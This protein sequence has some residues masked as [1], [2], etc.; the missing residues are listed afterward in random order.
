MPFKVIQGHRGG[1]KTIN[2]K[3]V[4]DF[5]LVININRHPISYRF[6]GIAAFCSNLGHFAFLSP[7]FLSGGSKHKVGQRTMFILGSLESV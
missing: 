2:R 1:I 5:L 4:C 3:P 7:P 6:G